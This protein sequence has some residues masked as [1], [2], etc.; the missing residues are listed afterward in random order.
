[1]QQNAGGDCTRKP[2]KGQHP[3]VFAGIVR[4]MRQALPHH[5]RLQ[6]RLSRAHEQWVYLSGGA[7]ALTGIGWLVCH[8]L[9]RAP[10]PAPHPLEVWWLRLHGAALLAFLVVVG[11]L[12]PAHVVYG[13]RHRMN[14][15]TGIPVLIVMALLTLTGYGLYYL[16]DDDW[17]SWASILHWS[18]GLLAVALL[19][20]HALRG[21]HGSR[22][23]LHAARH[24]VRARPPSHHPGHRPQA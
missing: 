5:P 13:W 3:D 15:G 19:T 23:R 24:E 17:R 7:L 18:V 16:V 2:V 21:K 22:A 4:G 10:G 12:L 20:L 1:M 8:F 14:L 6:Q 9:L 11:T